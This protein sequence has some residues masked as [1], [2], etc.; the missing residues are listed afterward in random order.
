MKL[1]KKISSEFIFMFEIFSSFE[2]FEI[3]LLFIFLGY[4]KL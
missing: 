3:S 2:F 1:K 4:Q